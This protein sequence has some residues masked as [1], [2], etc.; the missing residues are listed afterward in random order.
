MLAFHF[1]L[2][3]F[4]IPRKLDCWSPACRTHKSAENFHFELLLKGSTLN[5]VFLSKVSIFK[6]PASSSLQS[7]LKV[8]E[9]MMIGL[10]SFD[11]GKKEA[12]LPSRSLPDGTSLLSSFDQEDQEAQ[13]PSISLPDG[14]S[15]LNSDGSGLDRIHDGIFIQ[16]QTGF[17]I[18]TK[19]GK[20]QKMFVNVTFHDTIEVPGTKKKLDEKGKEVEGLNVP[21]SMGPIRKCSDKA[22]IECLVVDGIVNPVVRKEMEEDSTGSQRNF[23]CQLLMQ[24]FDQKYKDL[25]PL[26]RKYS[27]PKMDYFG[28]IHVTSGEICRKKSDKVE[29]VKQYVRD[30]RSTPKIEEIDSI[31]KQGTPRSPPLDLRISLQLL[32]GQMLSVQQYLDI[33]KSSTGSNNE[34]L[35]CFLP[36]EEWDK[37][38]PFIFDIGHDEEYCVTQIIVKASI[39][40]SD[41][42]SM[43]VSASVYSLH[44]FG[45]TFQPTQCILP[46]PVESKSVICNVD[47]ETLKLCVSVAVQTTS[48]DQNA[49]VGSGPWLM[50]RALSGGK[51][52]PKTKRK[53]TQDQKDLEKNAV[54]DISTDIM[55]ESDP[56]HLQSLFPWNRHQSSGKQQGSL[57]G[58]PEDRFH[59]KDS[60][61]QH[62]MQQQEGERTQKIKQSQDDKEERL[63]ENDAEY[64]NAADFKTSGRKRASIENDG[65]HQ[66]YLKRAEGVV[67][68]C[69][70]VEVNNLYWY[71]ML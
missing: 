60:V 56:F 67:K 23:V 38:F 36:D 22:G 21:L 9:S 1:S 16:P 45:S 13:L 31:L 58:L 70:D 59:N 46:F 12:Q 34:M 10:S 7:K 32:D 14:T 30:T 11:R 29:V 35:P 4:A 33:L 63:R 26:D 41:L 8:Q 17:V 64:V 25:A 37:S 50:A 69:V 40:A 51:A 42:D 43:T 27:L 52:N 19:S 28:Y 39:P 47:R 61:S 5:F 20:Q 48:K 53:S 6:Y 57:D 55:Q 68:R 71:K 24:C 66:E 44:L 3:S 54:S 65:E 15:I 18:K 49:D 2:I 62:L